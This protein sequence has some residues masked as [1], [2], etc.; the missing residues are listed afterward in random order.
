MRA[1]IFILLSSISIAQAQSVRTVIDFNKGWQFHLFDSTELK[2]AQP[3]ARLQWRNLDLPHDWSIDGPFSK[4]HL[5]TNQQAALPGGIALYKKSFQPTAAELQKN[6]SI[7]FDGVFCNSEVYVNGILV[8]KRPNG[9]ISFQ[10]NISKYVKPG[11]NIITVKV[12]NMAQPSSRWYTGSGIYRNVRLVYTNNVAID[13]WGT[14]VTTPVVSKESAVVKIDIDIRNKA[15]SNQFVRVETRILNEAGKMVAKTE[16]YEMT[17]RDT[18]TRISQQAL[19]ML[20]ELWSTDRPWLYKAITTI[21]DGKKIIDQYTTTFG[22]RYFSFD[23]QKGF[24]LNGKPMKILG[25]CM[26]HDLGA[27]GAAVNVRAMER[28]LQ[29]LKDMGC[30]A[31]R[32]AHNPPAPELLDLCDKMGFLVMDEAFDIWKKRK[33]RFDYHLHFDAWHKRDLEDMVKRDRNHPSVFMWSVG[34]EIREQFDSTGIRITRE[35][36]QIV[37]QL[38]TT[39]PVTAALT[40]TDTLKNFMYQANALD[41]IGLNYNH[42]KFEQLPKLFPGKNIIASETTSGLASRGDY[43]LPS[44]SIRYWP[45]RGEKYV[46]NGHA[47]FS[48][49]A[50]DHVAAY[51]GSTHEETWKKIKKL[52][53]ISGLFV[54]TG[55]DYLGEP[56][57]YPWPARSSYFGII[58]IAGFPKDVYYMYQSEWTTK[59]VL[60]IFPH[61]N[62]TPGTIVDVWGYY[63]NAD[64]VELFLNNR[65]LGI[66]KKQND[67]LHVQWKVPFEPGTLT[68]ISRK[69]GQAV[70]TKTIKTPSEPARIELT[71]DRDILHAGGNDLSF[72]TV[73]I[74]DKNGNL[75]PDAA[76][77]V[78]FSGS[79]EGVIAALDN[80]YPAGSEP[81]KAAFRKAYNGMAL[82]IIRSSSKKGGYRLT[83]SSDGLAPAT[84]AL[85]IR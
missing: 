63:N 33:T 74:L 40:E 72:I 76:N 85:K 60:H 84:I 32:T 31:I 51:W 9:Y 19:V 56:T 21:S 64:E 29:I 45:A 13:H 28:Q 2:D 53:F 65:S 68:A 47:D 12:D 54:W 77:L 24:S 27:L 67:D 6:I 10:Y 66:R 83:A 57:P 3:D 8:G 35:L 49:S 26:H 22:V 42:A 1:L 25:V 81:F 79:G 23:T 17:V 48:V 46:S 16:P 70:L 36:V 82:V 62:W 41:V 34:N 55:F 75:V 5:T 52:D 61:W 4:D 20:P 80:G 50:Y 38:D 18:I 43:D 15:Q 59:P 14:F 39:R 78:N 11:V 7:E 37:K 44:D 73:R 30:N 69:N 71:A 58:D